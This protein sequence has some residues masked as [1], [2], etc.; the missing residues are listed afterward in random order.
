MR[1][2]QREHFRDRRSRTN[3]DCQAV[4]LLGRRQVVHDA[5][6]HD[7]HDPAGRQL[8]LLDSNRQHVNTI[9]LPNTHRSAINR[10]RGAMI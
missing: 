4:R 10:Q 8:P 3:D 9:T 2:Q 5:I 1:D 7:G 6:G